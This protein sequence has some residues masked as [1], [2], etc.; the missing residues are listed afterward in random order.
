MADDTRYQGKNDLYP[1]GGNS[2]GGGPA[3]SDPLAELARLIGQNDPFSEFNRGRQAQEPRPPAHEPPPVE[4]QPSARAHDDYNHPPAAEPRF[5]DPPRQ[6]VEPEPYQYEPSRSLQPPPAA[7]AQRYEAPR[8]EEQ[9]YPEQ[10]GYQSGAYQ[11][12]SEPYAPSD[13]RQPQPGQEQTVYADYERPVQPAPAP[14]VPTYP[15]PTHPAYDER[16]APPTAYERPERPTHAAYDDRQIPSALD[17]SLQPPFE[18]PGQPPRDARDAPLAFARDPGNEGFERPPLAEPDMRGGYQPDDPMAR[19]GQPQ[20]DD[21]YDEAR[22]TRRR[23]G[24]ITVVAVLSLAVVGTAGA[25]GYRAMFGSSGS[26][27]APPVIRAD[28][29]PSKVVP[30]PI[31]T[32][33]ASSGKISYERVGGGGQGER[34]LPREETPIEVPTRS[35]APPPAVTAAVPP[36]PAAA[37][38]SGPG[39]PRKVRTV[40]IRPDQPPPAAETAARAPSGQ[41]FRTASAPPAPEAAPTRS[42]RPAPAAPPPQ[43][44]GT[45]PLPLTPEGTTLPPPPPAAASVGEGGYLVQISSQR[46]EADARSSFRTLQG[47][48]PTQLGDR[49][50]I[51]RRADLGEKG[52]FYRAQIG[53]FGSV[54]E[55]TKMCSELKAAG[56]QCVVSKN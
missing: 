8:H 35:V 7:P 40:T 30:P 55:A 49:Q 17:R 24:L 10:H 19:E 52:V 39:E 50:P 53:P 29:T 42:A 9:H 37:P 31:V 48:F 12:G 16:P 47:K 5:E 45:G 38:S 36:A 28:V 34:V 21:I 56:G 22:T 2:G 11:T 15:A 33:E 41:P 32:A 4:W 20:G 23:G 18:R 1:R 44:A 25:F 54:D 14:A 51:I 27:S 46:S 6:Y 43:P 3:A 13:D 26:A